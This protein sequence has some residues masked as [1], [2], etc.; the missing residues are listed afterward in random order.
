MTGENE[1]KPDDVLPYRD[2]EEEFALDEDEVANEQLE[3]TGVQKLLSPI[4]LILL[5]MFCGAAFIPF[6]ILYTVGWM[7]LDA[8]K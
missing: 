2:D 5:L 1:D 3:T 8:G 4:Y 6:L 7:A